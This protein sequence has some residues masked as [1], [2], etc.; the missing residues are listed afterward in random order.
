MFERLGVLAHHFFEGVLEFARLIVR[1][2]RKNI[3]YSYGLAADGE[4]AGAVVVGD[5]MG[6]KSGPMISPEFLKRYVFHWQKRCVDYVH[7]HG[8]PLIPHSCGNLGL[9]VDDLIDYLGIDAKH[10]CEDSYPNT[11]RSMV[12]ESRYWE[13]ST[14]IN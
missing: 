5:D 13:V 3:S 2:G 12:I 6:Y 11:R 4:M 9:I 8:K 1:G 7:E 14:W 10:S